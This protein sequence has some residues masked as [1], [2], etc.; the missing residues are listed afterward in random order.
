VIGAIG[1]AVGTCVTTIHVHEVLQLCCQIEAAFEHRGRFILAVCTLTHRIAVKS[2][3][4][5][6]KRFQ[7]DALLFSST[8][9]LFSGVLIF[10]STASKIFRVVWTFY[11][12]NREK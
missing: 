5:D 10:F 6:L 3:F 2:P 9:Q 1:Y 12:E 7:L 8:G 11:P 4:S